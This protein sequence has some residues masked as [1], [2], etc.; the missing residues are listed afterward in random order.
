M[1]FAFFNFFFFFKQKTAYEIGWCDW[2]SDVCSSDLHRDVVARERIRGPIAVVLATPRAEEDRGDERHDSAR[3]V[4]DGRSGEV[5]VAVAQ[6][7]VLAEHREPTAAPGPVSVDRI[8]D[9]ADEHAEHGERGKL[10]QIGQRA[11]RD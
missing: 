11:G 4:D 7:E 10:T 6:P 9:C 3:H 2:S 1:L 8:N 5:D